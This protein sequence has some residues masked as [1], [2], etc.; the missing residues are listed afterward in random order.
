MTSNLP[1]LL[2]L[3]WGLEN[4]EYDF[5]DFSDLNEDTFDKPFKQEQQRR[6]QSH[7]PMVMQV[8]LIS[9]TLISFPQQTFAQIPAQAH[10]AFIQA[11]RVLRQSNIHTHFERFYSQALK[12]YPL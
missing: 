5:S 10:S 12:S 1:I 2:L 3:Y 9:T 8:H 4:G 11:Y 7:H 6:A